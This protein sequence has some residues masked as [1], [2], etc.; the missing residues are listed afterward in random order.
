MSELE[1]RL[2][3]RKLGDERRHRNKVRFMWHE[4][5]VKSGSDL[6]LTAVRVAGLI[7][8]AYTLSSTGVVALSNADMAREL[9]ITK[10]ARSARDQGLAVSSPL[11]RAAQS[12]LPNCVPQHARRLADGCQ[13]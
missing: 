3:E 2:A 13:N 7:M 9:R 5:L 1:Q 11:P 8:H 6:T 4:Q 10:R 12:A